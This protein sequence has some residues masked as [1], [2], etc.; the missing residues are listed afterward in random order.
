MTM[1]I[2]LF[3]M[4]HIVKIQCDWAILTAIRTAVKHYNTQ[5][6]K[7]L[8]ENVFHGHRRPSFL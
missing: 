8:A 7:A 1:Q 3:T 5:V 6:L 4:Y 2:F